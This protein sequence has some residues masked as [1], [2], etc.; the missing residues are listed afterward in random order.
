MDKLRYISSESY[1]EG[2]IVEV[3]DGSV[4][5]ELKGRMGQMRLPKRMVISD[6]ELKMG[7]EV[8]FLLTYPEVISDEIDEKYAK[9]AKRQLEKRM[10]GGSKL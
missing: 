7:Q 4:V 9:N 8:G 10:K 5:I 3:T 1:Y 6:D 2:I